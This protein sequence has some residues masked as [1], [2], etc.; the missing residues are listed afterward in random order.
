[1]SYAKQ[2]IDIATARTLQVMNIADSICER[3]GYRG[4]AWKIAVSAIVSE[5]ISRIDDA[6]VL[7]QQSI[8]LYK[9]RN[10]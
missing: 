9:M 7:R 2:E 1:M 5:Q 4:D 6:T 10:K 8:E 3:N